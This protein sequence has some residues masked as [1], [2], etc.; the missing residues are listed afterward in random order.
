[1]VTKRKPGTV[2]ANRIPILDRHGN[3][4]GHVGRTAT[5]ATVARFIGHHG[6]MLTKVKGRLSWVEQTPN[7][8]Q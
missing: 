3:T 7:K 4:R 8:S 2:P 5:Q 6:A 1:M